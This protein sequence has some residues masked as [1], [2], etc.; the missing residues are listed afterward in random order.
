M[1]VNSRKITSSPTGVAD[2]NSRVN[3][4]D[5][6]TTKHHDEREL[7]KKYANIFTTMSEQLKTNITK[8]QEI[9]KDNNDFSEL[10]KIL[11]NILRIIHMNK[12]LCANPVQRKRVKFIVDTEKFNSGKV[13]EFCDNMQFM[14]LEIQEIIDN[15]DNFTGKVTTMKANLTK[16][17]YD[18][19]AKLVG[20]RKTKKQKRQGR[21]KKNKKTKRRRIQKKTITKCKK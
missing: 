14:I 20:G 3:P 12:Q 13:S 17:G 21:T 4:G 5:N 2:Y 6:N 8:Y 18:Y 9:N 10:N 11:E 7:Q 15:N 16:Y 1:P 19:F